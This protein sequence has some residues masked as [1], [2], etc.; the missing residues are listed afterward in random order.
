M[1]SKE[2]QREHKIKIAMDAYFYNDKLHKFEL[3]KPRLNF[4]DYFNFMIRHRQ[5]F[6]LFFT[7]A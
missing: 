5:K 2:T 7:T 1:S 4:F 6:I 3:N